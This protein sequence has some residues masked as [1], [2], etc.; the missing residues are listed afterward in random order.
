MGALFEHMK[1]NADP[2]REDPPLPDEAPYVD[3]MRE[4]AR[5]FSALWP[6]EIETGVSRQHFGFWVIWLAQTGKPWT[7]EHICRLSLEVLSSR[8]TCELFLYGNRRVEFEDFE[9]FKSCMNMVLK[10]KDS[11]VL[12]QN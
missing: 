8:G 6:G 7:K 12:T 11:H 4:T 5:S 1:R 9:G 3:L 10:A 2:T